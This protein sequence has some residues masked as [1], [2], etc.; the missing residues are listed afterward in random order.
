MSFYN[1][2]FGPKLYMEYKGV[3]EP[4]V[5]S[6]IHTNWNMKHNFCDC[7]EKCMNPVQLKSSANKYCQ[8]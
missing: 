8:R 3:P 5:F 2:I 4:Q 7:S 1:Y 6:G